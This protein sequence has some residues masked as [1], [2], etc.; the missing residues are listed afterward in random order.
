[1]TAF[2]Q[3]LFR[4]VGR[5]LGTLLALVAIISGWAAEPNV[6]F[7]DAALRVDITQAAFLNMNR[8]DVEASFKAFAETVGRR[9]GYRIQTTTTI[10][11]DPLELRSA[12]Q[13]GG[14]SLIIIDSWRYL[15]MGFNGL[16]KPYYIPADRGRVGKKYLIL[17]RRDS[18]L[19]TVASLKGKDMVKLEFASVCMGAYWLETHLLANR[20]GP[21]EAFFSRVTSV[22]KPAAAV[23]PVFFGTRPA[24]LVDEV[25]FQIMKELNP[26]VGRVLQSVAVS[27]VLVDAVVCLSLSGWPTDEYRKD[28]AQALGE[29]HLDP[30]GQQ[31]LTLFK[32]E[33]LVPFQEAH[34]ETMRALRKTYEESQIKANP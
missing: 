9:R 13:K 24:C 17:T 27:E 19:D 31:I 20:L 4:S 10:F 5:A 34:L 11:E 15:S 26:Q 21:S 14:S 25:S 22:G 3:E 1:M 28:L 12:I 32:V 23:L 16:L 29:L 8:N 6:A 33:Q 18:G 2:F 7:R 30:A